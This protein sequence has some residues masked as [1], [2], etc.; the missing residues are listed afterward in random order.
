MSKKLVLIIF[1]I[2]L[3]PFFP[4]GGS[5][6]YTDGVSIQGYQVGGLT[7]A[8]ARARLLPYIEDVLHQEV[9]LVAPHKNEIWVTSYDELGISANLEAALDEGLKAGKKGFLLQRWYEKIRI[10]QKGYNI[11]LQLI[12][13]EKRARA[14]ILHLT[15]ELHKDPQDAKFVIERNKVKIQKEIIGVGI[16]TAA[17]INS[18][19]NRLVLQGPLRLE[20]VIQEVSPSKTEE[21]LKQLKIEGLLG[22]YTTWF[23]PSKTNRTQNIRKAAEAIHDYIL[24]PGKEFSFN[25]IVGPRTKESGYNDAPIILNNQ[26]AQG[27]GGGVCQVSSTLYN[28]LLKTNLSVTERHPHSLPIGY[29]PKGMDAAV[30]YGMKDL[31]F[32]NNFQGHLLIKAYVGQSTITI[33]IFGPSN[34]GNKIEIIS[35]VEKTFNPKT[36]IKKRNDLLSGQVIVEQHGTAGYIVRVERIIRDQYSNIL[37]HELLTRDYYPPIDKIILVAGN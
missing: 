12:L 30:V 4:M 37:V 10:R 35:F 26:F 9:L 3:F 21:D 34:G 20:V 24:A 36:T 27:V 8:A 19:K 5:P 13:D 14:Q 16:D 29:V 23:N 6:V 17:M 11:P 18:L 28:V 7:R 25:K 1:F 31:K 22:E 15:A 33:K 2:L 32:V